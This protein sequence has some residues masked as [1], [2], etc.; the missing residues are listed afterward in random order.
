[1]QA[2]SVIDV[3]LCSDEVRMVRL[4]ARERVKKNEAIPGPICGR[5]RID[6]ALIGMLAEEAFSKALN[7][8]LDLS[9]RPTLHDFVLMGYFIDLK[10]TDRPNGRLMTPAT[11][12]AM[13][14]DRYVLATVNTVVDPCA[15]RLVGF[16]TAAELFD[17]ANLVDVGHGATY[18]LPQSRLHPLDRI[19]ERTP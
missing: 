9:L 8:H 12:L 13:Q 7:L 6:T 15:V 5:E 16:A 3:S 4:F 1:M 18:A 2:R 11:K 19:L 14:A 10:A 17:P